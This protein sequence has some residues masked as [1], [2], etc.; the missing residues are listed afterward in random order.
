[1]L[2]HAILE[3]DKICA[4]VKAAGEDSEKLDGIRPGMSALYRLDQPITGVILAVMRGHDCVI[5]GK[6]YYLVCS[7]R[8]DASGVMEDLLFHDRRSNR[9]FP[10]KRMRNGV[11]EARLEYETIA[12]N[13]DEDLSFVKVNLGTGRTHQIRAQFASRKMPLAGDG[14]YG[15]RVKC[16]LALIC[17]EVRFTSKGREYTASIPLPDTYP[18]ELFK[19][20]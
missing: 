17:K 19:Q 12:Y 6:D 15:S 7:G 14:K 3:T 9:S 16:D 13:P 10:V 1:M 2:R 20:S 5:T 18:W 11:R 8:C 4:Y